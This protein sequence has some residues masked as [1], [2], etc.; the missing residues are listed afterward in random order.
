MWC[1]RKFKK[2]LGVISNL[3]VEAS[4]YIHF[5]LYKRWQEGNF[6]D[7]PI[8]FLDFYYP[9]LDKPAAKYILDPKYKELRGNL[10]FYV[11][12][13]RS[14]L[15][16]N[17]SLIFETCFKN[18]LFM[19]GYS[20]VRRF[21]RGFESDA[22]V[23][24]QTLDT[25]F[26]KNSKFKPNDRLIEQMKSHLKYDGNGL[27]DIQAKYFRHIKFFY[28][29]QCY[30]HERGLKN[31]KLVPEFK[32]GRH[33]I[34]YDTKAFWSLLCSVGMFQGKKRQRVCLCQ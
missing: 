6:H 24:Y 7:K 19:H 34:A 5:E 1:T 23:V 9:L 22:K 15:Y 13:H 16:V 26:N 10:E 29:L 8:N 33:H 31:F 25:L 30:N 12:K 18:N 2:T 17:Q 21:L 32:S 28:M 20:R 4:I 14:N 27:H 11:K 3:T